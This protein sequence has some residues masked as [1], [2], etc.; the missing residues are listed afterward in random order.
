M[1]T[2]ERKMRHI[3]ELKGTTRQRLS[4]IGNMCKH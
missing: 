1:G 2:T 4:C 3:S